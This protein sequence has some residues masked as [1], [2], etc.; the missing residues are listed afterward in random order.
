MSALRRNHRDFLI[1]GGQEMGAS[2]NVLNFLKRLAA[3]LRGSPLLQTCF[4]RRH[5]LRLDAQW[6]GEYIL[7]FIPSAFRSNAL[8]LS[9]SLV[10]QLYILIEGWR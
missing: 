8:V 7:S 10:S 4:I 1:L 2:S 3:P 9:Y 6:G 5:Y